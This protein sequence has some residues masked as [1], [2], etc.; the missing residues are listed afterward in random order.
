MCFFLN[1]LGQFI[2]EFKTIFFEKFP[3]VKQTKTLFKNILVV[4]VDDDLNRKFVNKDEILILSDTKKIKC[5][6]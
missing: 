2:N 6:D 5:S 4:V 3:G 1:K